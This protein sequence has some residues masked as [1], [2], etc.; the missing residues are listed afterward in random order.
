MF[1]PVPSLSPRLGHYV[2]RFDLIIR[3]IGWCWTKRLEEVREILVLTQ[4]KIAAY[5]RNLDSM[6]LRSRLYLIIKHM[7]ATVDQ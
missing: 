6:P 4:A 7:L 3:D 1:V 5:L 2:V